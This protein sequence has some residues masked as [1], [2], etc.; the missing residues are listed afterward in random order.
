MISYSKIIADSYQLTVR[1]KILWLFGLFVI[2]GFNVNFFQFQKI[3]LREY[4]SHFQPLHVLG[5]FVQHPLVLAGASLSVLIVSVLG[6]A[7]TNWSRVMLIRCAHSIIADKHMHVEREIRLS[8]QSLFSIIRLSLTTTLLIV[9]AAGVLFIPPF[10]LGFEINQQ[11]TLWTAGVVIFLPIAFTISCVNIFA[12]F[13]IVLLKR[14]LSS[15][16]TLGTDFFARNWTAILGLSL[17]LMV[18]YVLAFFV[19]IA[20]IYAVKIIFEI[21]TELSGSLGVS[22]FSAI[23]RLS[24]ILGNILLWVLLAGLNVFFNTALLLLFLQLITPVKFEEQELGAP[25]PAQ[26]LE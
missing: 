16:I 2:G 1:N 23:M 19:G 4:H 26:A 15:A 20:L 17:I 8:K 21:A 25:I 9:V 14:S 13:F 22:Y 10:F 12:S 6:L 18:I 11:Q 5:F 3:P 24:A 7:V